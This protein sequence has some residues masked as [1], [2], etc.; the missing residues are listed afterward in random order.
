MTG[1]GPHTS[2]QEVR[3]RT[4]VKGCAEVPGNWSGPPT[5]CFWPCFDSGFRVWS[6]PAPCL[7]LRCA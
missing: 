6:T 7:V 4:V 2:R 3:E 1:H 5:L